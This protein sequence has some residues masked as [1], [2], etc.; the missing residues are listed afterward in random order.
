MF[1]SKKVD[2]A[3]FSRNDPWWKTTI[4]GKEFLAYE[5]VFLIGVLSML[6]GMAVGGFVVHHYTNRAVK[7]VVSP[8]IT[9]PKKITKPDVEQIEAASP[10]AIPQIDLGNNAEQPVYLVPDIAKKG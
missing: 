7:V 10:I 8:S 1:K 2:L 4:W 9:A 5:V 6:V 3:K